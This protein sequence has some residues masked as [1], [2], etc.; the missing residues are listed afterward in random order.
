[1]PEFT[2]NERRHITSLREIESCREL[3]SRTS[4]LERGV[5]PKCILP[6]EYDESW[7]G[8]EFS[9]EMKS[10]ALGFDEVGAFWKT[11]EDPPEICGEF[12][13]INL[14]YALTSED[15]G[16]AGAGTDFQ[17]QFLRQLCPI[18]RSPRSG[19]GM[20]TYMRMQAGVPELE[21]WHSGLFSVEEPPYPSG[22]VRLDIDY[23]EYL[24][25]LL[26]TKGTYGW[27]FLFADVTLSG[28]ELSDQAKYIRRMLQVFPALFP[29]Y[30]Y[31]SLARRFEARL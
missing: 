26:L 25:A 3:D 11:R 6:E 14:D 29:Q 28:R 19:A 10:S 4:E 5:P 12:S 20:Q 13:L 18:D 16:E 17:R 7:E 30:D 8:I 22:F 24:D 31:A 9:D 2:E 27:Q 1:M 21:I 23:C 15:P